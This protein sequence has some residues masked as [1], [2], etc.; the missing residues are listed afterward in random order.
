[1]SNETESE[2]LR[3]ILQFRNKKKFK[4]SLNSKLT[5]KENFIPYKTLWLINSVYPE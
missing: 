4:N 3:L 5:I 2:N 1:M